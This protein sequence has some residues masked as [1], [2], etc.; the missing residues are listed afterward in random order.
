[1]HVLDL[2]AKIVRDIVAPVGL[3]ILGLLNYRLAKRKAEKGSVSQSTELPRSF[4][5]KKEIIGFL[6]S[7][8]TVSFFMTLVTQ[9][10]YPPY[11]RFAPAG[12]K[13]LLSPE[14]IKALWMLGLTVLLYILGLPQL[15]I[16]KWAAA[17]IRERIAQAIIIGGAII[18]AAIILRR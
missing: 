5:E 12:W 13:P 3:L 17:N 11:A 4:R 9:Y 6:V 15:V 1:M 18:I 16:Q 7:V 2:I 8:A 14:V 10:V